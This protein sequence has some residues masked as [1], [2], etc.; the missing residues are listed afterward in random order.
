MTA[1]AIVLLIVFGILLILLEFLVVPGITIAGI[2]GLL[3]L[4]G[5]V[6][7][8]YNT[9][10]STIGSYT[11]LATFIILLIILYYSLRSKTW[12][13]L[14]LNKSID[15]HVEEVE[16]EKIKK[17]DIGVTITRLAPIGKVS[18][19]D[20]EVE[21]KS[22]DKF[23]DQDTEIEVIKVLKNQIIVKLKNR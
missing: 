5:G 6:Y 15:S 2:G 18:V 22:I 7:M 9:Y 21:G 13:K 12:N 16:E 10:G 4:G 8:S 23:I 20:V 3:L 11:L 1:L 19:N 17:G 14:M